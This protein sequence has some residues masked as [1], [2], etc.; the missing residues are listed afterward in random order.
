ML[1]RAA[2]SG[3]SRI[4]R[5]TGG[6]LDVACALGRAGVI[7]AER[8]REGDGGSPAGIWPLR[9]VLYRPDRLS[10]PRTALP[11]AALAPDDGWCDAPGDRL[12][13]RP[14]KRP[15]PAGAE[16]LWREDEIY[17]VFVELGYNDAPA[18][19]GAGSCIFWHLAR[20]EF[21][22]TQGCVA[23]APETMRA[24]LAVARPGDALEIVL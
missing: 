15:Y 19:A 3:G 23:V 1:F 7:A 22:P 13:N 5:F 9:R 8:K 4:A 20:A 12:Y 17:D 24:A 6:G 21:S 10:A 11:V 18:V 2:A 14:V 16:R